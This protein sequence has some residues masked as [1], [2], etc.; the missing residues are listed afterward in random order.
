MPLGAQ[1]G[2]PGMR[3][4]Q[5]WHSRIFQGLL[6][7]AGAQVRPH[8]RECWS[9]A[10]MAWQ[11]PW[12][13]KQHKPIICVMGSSK[14]PVTPNMIKISISLLEKMWPGIFHSLGVF[15]LKDSFVLQVSGWNLITAH[16][17]TNFF[18]WLGANLGSRRYLC[19]FP[20]HAHTMLKRFL[21]STVRKI[22]GICSLS[23][24]LVREMGR[25]KASLWLWHGMTLGFI[26]RAVTYG[27][28]GFGS[29]CWNELM[30]SFCLSELLRRHFWLGVFSCNN[31]SST[32][33]G[34]L[35]SEG[36]LWRGCAS[37]QCLQF[38]FTGLRLVPWVPQHHPYSHVVLN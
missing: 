32:L 33:T 19:P 14:G 21:P 13:R 22:R 23:R 25:W 15:P 12:R 9:T 20:Q 31:S 30:C 4:L 35:L 16:I 36:S 27:P 2:L 38:S 6:S 37:A 29:C 3:E 24:N 7:K 1:E 17:N 28:Q 11:A 34:K 26:G 8:N 10:E 5:E 18:D